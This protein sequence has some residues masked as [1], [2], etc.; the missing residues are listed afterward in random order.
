MSTDDKGP[1]KDLSEEGMSLRPHLPCLLT[2]IEA[3]D[4]LRVSK[5]TIYSWVEKNRL[6]C[7]RAGTLLRFKQ[8]DLDAWLAGR[9]RG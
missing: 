9:E 1:N 2:V 4:Y 3:A 7:L 5:S 6:P 8:S